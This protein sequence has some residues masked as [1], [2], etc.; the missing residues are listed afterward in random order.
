MPETKES[1]LWTEDD[2]GIW[3]GSC[4]AVW[5]FNEGGPKDN[6]MNFCAQCGRPLKEQPYD[7]PTDEE[8]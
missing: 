7:E 1:C 8:A 2:D 3:C 6:K 5:Q 4:G